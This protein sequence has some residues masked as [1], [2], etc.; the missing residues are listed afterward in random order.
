MVLGD[1]AESDIESGGAE[2][3]VE[4]GGAE[5]DVESG[6]AE[7]DVESGGA[8]S[9]VESGVVTEARSRAGASRV[10]GLW[11]DVVQMCGISALTA[12]FAE[13]GIT[14]GVASG[15]DGGAS[16]RGIGDGGDKHSAEV[17]GWS[18]L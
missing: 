12:V 16:K 18:G 4:S 9:D 1:G 5:S 11:S 13:A 15:V 6:G 8:E 3:D 17:D 2:S 10:D 14:P 7:N